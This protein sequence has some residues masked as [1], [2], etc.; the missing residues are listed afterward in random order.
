MDQLTDLQEKQ[1]NLCY[2]ADS[3]KIIESNYFL[4]VMHSMIIFKED[5]FYQ[6]FHGPQ[7]VSLEGLRKKIK[8]SNYDEF[9]VFLI[10]HT[11]FASIKIKNEMKFQTYDFK[12]EIP[13][14]MKIIYTFKRKVTD[15]EK[16][17]TL[18]SPKKQ[19]ITKSYL[20]RLIK[21]KIERSIRRNLLFVI[22]QEDTSLLEAQRYLSQIRERVLEDV[23]NRLSIYG[24]DVNL[25]FENIDFIDNNEIIKLREILYKHNEMNT[26]GYTYQQEHLIDYIELTTQREEDEKTCG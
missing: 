13:I 3:K 2:E 26:L 22:K 25:I 24:I 11:D 23:T 20:D 9:S 6:E 5:T 8:N 16:F 19:M 18:L 21:P 14:E 1:S 7:I 12:Y 17:I 10:D 15:Y 4:D